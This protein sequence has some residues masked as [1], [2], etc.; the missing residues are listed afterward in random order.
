MI[1]TH[2]CGFESGYDFGSADHFVGSDSFSA[3]RIQHYFFLTA[4]TKLEQSQICKRI[5]LTKK[6]SYILN[7]L[8]RYPNKVFV[9]INK[10]LHK[11]ED[12]DAYQR[13]CFFLHKF[14]NLDAHHNDIGYYINLRIRMLIK[15]ELGFYINFF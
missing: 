4:R 15:I 3:H 10:L 5:K 8:L 6:I 12:P 9:C 14:E 11:I 13:F 7:P 2:W 1:K